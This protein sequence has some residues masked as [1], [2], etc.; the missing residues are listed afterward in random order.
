MSDILSMMVLRDRVKQILMEPTLD[1]G[2]T[3]F[4]S[5]M[6]VAFTV[7]LL[8]P[9]VTGVIQQELLILEAL[10]CISATI[11]GAAY[12]RFD[13]EARNANSIRMKK[14]IDHE[15]LIKNPKLKETE[16]TLDY[17]E[18]LQNEMSIMRQLLASIADKLING[19]IDKKY[20]DPNLVNTDA[21]NTDTTDTPWSKKD[22]N[23]GKVKN[24][25]P[26]DT[27]KTSED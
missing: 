14:D 16:I 1:K 2:F 27:E 23:A 22:V 7:T 15:Y 24:D 19:D 21:I 17:I 12:K 20:Y 26:M 5:V 11:I 6:L 9:L 13:Q 10:S 4:A 8:S 18:T 25:P 3:A